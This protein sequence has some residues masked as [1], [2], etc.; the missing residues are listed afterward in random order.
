MPDFFNPAYDAVPNCKMFYNRSVASKAAVAFSVTNNM[1][2]PQGKTFVQADP[3]NI[4][5]L[6]DQD[7]WQNLVNPQNA[8]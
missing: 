5:R 2:A 7:L 1:P 4:A 3:K 6:A 8:R